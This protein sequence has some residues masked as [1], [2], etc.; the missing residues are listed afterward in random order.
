MVNHISFRFLVIYIVKFITNSSTALLGCQ[1]EKNLGLLNEAA[2]AVKKK[3]YS[4][5]HFKVLV[6]RKAEKICASP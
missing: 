4:H 2:S 3:N 1:V 5:S 6:T